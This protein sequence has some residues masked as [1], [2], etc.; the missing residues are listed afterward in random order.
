MKKFLASFVLALMALMPL[1][2]SSIDWT[3]LVEKLAK[4][5]VYIETEQGACSGSVVND[6]AGD[7]KDHDFILTAAHCAGK[8]MY[9]NQER[10]FV[11]AKDVPND[12]L[13]LDML[14]T[15]RPALRV[16]AKDP[17]VGQEIASLGYGYALEKPL[18]RVTHVSAIQE[19]PELRGPYV[20]TDTTFVPGQS[21]GP[22]I[23]ASGELA[24]IVQAGTNSVGVGKGAEVIRA[25]LGRFFSATPT[26]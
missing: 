16:A 12:L 18:F 26:K 10:A 15:G 20:F 21:G 17:E 24:M 6:A 8:E 14:D 7:K 3:L 5:T 23:N 25:K 22:V 11:K 4:S 2:A 19:I 9:V 13:L 1:N